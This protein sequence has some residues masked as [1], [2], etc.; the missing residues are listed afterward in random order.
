[1][2]GCEERVHQSLVHYHPKELFEAPY[3]LERKYKTNLI[4]KF[5]KNK[6]IAFNF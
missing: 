5:D 1:M 4:N 2:V 3:H 6:G